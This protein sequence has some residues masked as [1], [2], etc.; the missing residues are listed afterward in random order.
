MNLSEVTE[1]NEVEE[2]F[3]LK[4]GK[5]LKIINE[6]DE[7]Y[8][9]E[10]II[11]LLKPGKKLK[12]SKR[13]GSRSSS[14][15]HRS[16]SNE[17]LK[18]A[19]RAVSQI[20]K[21]ADIEPSQEEH[22]LKL[23]VENVRK[24]SP[25]RKRMVKKELS[26]LES[27]SSD[28]SMTSDSSGSVDDNPTLTQRIPVVYKEE[29]QQI[30]ELERD[31]F[32]IQYKKLK[33]KKI[34][35]TYPNQ[36]S[37][38]RDIA[39]SFTDLKKVIQLVIGRTQSG[40][41][42]CMVEFLKF[43]IE[44]NLI[45]VENIYLIT[46]LSSKDWEKQ[47]K[48]RFPGAIHTHIYHN[49]QLSKFKRAVEGKQNI[50]VLIDETHM[51][52]QVKQTMS[53]VF[54]EL[55]WKLDFMMENDI[56]LVQF[57]ATPDGMLYALN[58]IKWPKEHVGIHIMPPGLGYFG[59][60]EM[61]MRN[62]LF[63]YSNV[64]GRDKEGAFEVEESSIY[65]NIE[66]I[67]D[68]ALTR[69]DSPKY[70]LFRIR[71]PNE[72]WYE[73]NI[74][75]TLELRFSEKDRDKFDSDP[76]RFHYYT[77]DGSIND[78]PKFLTKT[79][80]KFTFVMIK[81]KL[82][83]AQTLEFLE[84]S[85]DGMTVAKTH[86][87]KHNIGV[88]VERWTKGVETK[89][90]NDSFVI[91]GFLG[92]LCGYEEHNVICFTNLGS[93]E[94]Y[95]AM[96][97]SEFDQSVTA[98]T[99]WNSSTTRTKCGKTTNRRVLNEVH[100]MIDDVSEDNDDPYLSFKRVPIII[101]MNDDMS[102]FDLIQNAR[103]DKREQA[104]K[105]YLANNPDFSKLSQFITH[106]DVKKKQATAPDPVKPSYYKHI[107]NPVQKAKANQSFS[108]DLSPSDKE[109]SNWQCFIDIKDNRLVFIVWSLDPE[110]Y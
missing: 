73:D 98:E 87:I 67:L 63:Q 80:T 77:M 89:K 23:T 52:C 5:T 102:D 41:T 72:D 84:Y 45:P 99:D 88:M 43:F 75:N 97:E 110:L 37:T 22:L 18:I 48:Q 68:T 66:T 44:N 50:L 83:C 71:G 30:I 106:P 101:D 69:F 21:S 86:N 59:P 76:G 79:P 32:N 108:I 92:R 15:T 26:E 10:E 65:T 1:Y 74:R 27:Q 25:S 12:V 38:G 56:K 105:T 60:R 14:P 78:L 95:E 24:L 82:K 16:I 4:S 8:K 7:E 94:K 70:L 42:G 35:T 20:S 100:Q 109:N 36:V 19:T 9:V 96:W 46:G 81:E 3:P 13:G 54:K 28:G 31:E 61:K 93:I 47:C 39:T 103:G 91:Q 51:A 17:N 40:K 90:G 57:S 34:L 2:I 55:H 29:K 104:I 53:N 62:Q 49:G 6:Y 85:Q 107:V 64:Y 11:P 58:Q 33:V